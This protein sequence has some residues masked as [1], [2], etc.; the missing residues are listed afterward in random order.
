MATPALAGES[1]TPA[2]A[3]SIESLYEAGKAALS[4]KKPAEALVHFKSALAGSDG[5]SAITWQ[6]LLAV[7]VAYKDLGY[8]VHTLEYFKRFL[9]VTAP[10]QDIASEKWKRRRATVE[11]QI[12]ELEGALSLT[13]GFLSLTS[14]PSGAKVFV[15]GRRAGADKNAVTPFRLILTPGAHTVRLEKEGQEVKEVT[16]ELSAGAR[17]ERQVAMSAITVKAEP[18]EPPPVAPPPAPVMKESPQ[19]TISVTATET[20]GPSIAPWIVM[21]SGAAAGAVG[22]AMSLLAEGE[23][24]ALTR[25][26]NEGPPSQEE[27]ESKAAEWRSH[28]ASLATYESVAIAM[29]ALAGAAVTGGLIW[30]LVDSPDDTPHTEQTVFSV[31]VTPTPGGVFSHAKWSF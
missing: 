5:R 4:A 27:S 2:T 26:E 1:D 13:Y 9:T 18:A 8:P 15:D 25:L 17:E 19:P 12:N 21:G 6:M 30:A 22:I 28:E 20:Q 11:D 7:A 10:H 23:S 29:Y 14:T 3:E 31:G 24:E 16:V